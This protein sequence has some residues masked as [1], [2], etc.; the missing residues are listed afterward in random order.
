[1]TEFNALPATGVSLALCLS[2][3]A[4]VADTEQHAKWHDRTETP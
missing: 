2:C 3:G 4:V 1:M